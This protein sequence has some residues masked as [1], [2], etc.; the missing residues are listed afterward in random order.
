MIKHLTLAVLATLAPAVQA[1][2]LDNNAPLV[3]D[4]TYL[5][6]AYAGER[7]VAVGDRGNILYSDDLGDHWQAAKTP[8]RVLLTA[9]CFADEHH[10]WAVGHD[11]TVLASNDGGRTWQQQYSDVLGEEPETAQAAEP[12]P[13][14]DEYA[15]DD[16]YSSDPYGDPY[17]DD[18]GTA[19]VDTSGA[20]LLD[21]HC[22]SRDQAI[23][24]GGYGYFLE[25]RDGGKSW[26]KAMDRLDSNKGWHLYAYAASADNKTHYMTG[27]KGLL[28]QSRDAGQSWQTL[29]SPYSGTLFGV[30]PLA[31]HRVLIHGLQGRVFLT[32]DDGSS[33]T[34]VPT[35]LSRGVNDGAQLKDGTVVLVAN[36][37]GIL[38]S[39]DGGRTFSQRF[40]ADRESIS[41][42]LPLPG[43]DIFIAGAEG[44]RV[45]DAIQ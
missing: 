2:F 15:M 18:F 10:G 14:S 21:V 42:V 9:V 40:L 39:H 24:I 13:A 6:L 29:T 38:T 41:A 5:D 34:Q 27:E 30:T 26:Q 32:T 37:G 33:W 1:D 8:S 45:I 16:L 12:A 36:A 20:P 11:A 31:D 28:L 44:V 25:T 22:H 3:T 19:S 7:V 43:G 4:N 17:G 23:A 35:T